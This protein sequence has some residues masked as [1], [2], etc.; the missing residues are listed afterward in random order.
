MSFFAILELA[1]GMIFAWLF[2][3]IS[4]MFLQEWLAGLLQW[5]PNML[6]KTL[7]NLTG[8]KTDNAQLYSHP[9]IQSLHSGPTSKNKP[10]YIPSKQFSLAIMDM[11][12]NAPSEAFQI[13][14]TIFDIID[15]LEQQKPKNYI[16]AIAKLKSAVT[17][18]QKAI[19]ANGNTEAS[20][21]ALEVVK[22]IIRQVES[23][24]PKV[25]P[26]LQKKFAE[27]NERQK[28]NPT[29]ASKTD[30][31]AGLNALGLTS[32]NLQRSLNALS[33]DTGSDLSSLD[34]S[35]NQFRENIE[36]WF[37]NTMD[38]LNGWYKRRAQF[39]AFG[40]GLTM[41][42]F[43]NI[44][45]FELA[46]Q[47][48]RDPTVRQVIA[49][50]ATELVE[51]NQNGASDIDPNEVLTLAMQIDQLNIPVGWIGSPLPMSSDRAVFVGDN[52]QK[53]CVFSP[54]STVELSG[55]PLG[56]YCYPIINTPVTDDIYGW[57]L[58]FLGFLVTAVATAQGAP[59]WFDI[60]KNLVNIRSSG[61]APAQ[62]VT[63]TS[64][65]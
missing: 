31:S 64:N 10:S 22:Q 57:I 60:L 51:S 29:A 13:Q 14:F 26:I 54:G 1:I 3:S 21:K 42:I 61:S 52:F 7:E 44:D 43:F 49:I 24:F 46:N 15:D 45:S 50:Q 37:N 33:L 11:I 38:R 39:L 53:R 36:A 18:T 41:A 17:Y 62:S 8:S 56:D 19:A 6:E 63:V 30:L 35:L 12:Q 27:Y 47:L 65:K 32:P 25:K 23:E 2:M 58:K 16:K 9:L 59:F 5:R 48:W 28:A 4:A 34:R 55:L 20:K 40:I